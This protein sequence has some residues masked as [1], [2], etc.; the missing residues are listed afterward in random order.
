MLYEDPD[1]DASSRDRGRERKFAFA[2]LAGAALHVAALL[3]LA[4]ATRAGHELSSWPVLVGVAPLVILGAVA[5]Q[6]S[7]SMLRGGATAG[8]VG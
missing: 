3:W 2:N 6:A 8:G 5:L 1:A 7:T 4:I